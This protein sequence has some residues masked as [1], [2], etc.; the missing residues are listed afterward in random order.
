MERTIKRILR[1]SEGEVAEAVK[2]WLVNKHDIQLG[3]GA[4]HLTFFKPSEDKDYGLGKCEVE[5]QEEAI[6]KLHEQED[7]T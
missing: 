1:L 2:Y 6:I 7:K 4:V 3:S 5:T